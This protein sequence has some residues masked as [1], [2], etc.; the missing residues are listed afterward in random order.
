MSDRMLKNFKIEQLEQLFDERR[1]DRD[2]LETLFVELSLR[3]TKRA[4]S[5]KQRVLQALSVSSSA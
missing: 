5:L 3:T 1:T 4:R 2:F